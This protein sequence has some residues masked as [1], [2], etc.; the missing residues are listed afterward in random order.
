MFSR[1]FDPQLTLGKQTLFCLLANRNPQISTKTVIKSRLFN[2]SSFLFIFKLEHYGT[3]YICKEK[4]YVP[5][6]RL[7]EISSPRKGSGTQIANPQIT[8]PPI[9]L[10]NIGPQIAKPRGAIGGP[11]TFAN[12]RFEV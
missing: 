4:K 12:N 9:L 11:T 8:N 6:L 2:P 5:I 10:N 3:C 7:A 1:K